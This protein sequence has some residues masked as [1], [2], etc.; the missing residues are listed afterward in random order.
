MRPVEL[1]PRRRRV[2]AAVGS[3]AAHTGLAVLLVMLRPPPTPPAA[4]ALIEIEVVPAPAVA[5]APAAPPPTSG[6]SAVPGRT[7]AAA[8]AGRRGRAVQVRPSEPADPLADLSIRYEAPPGA[9]TGARGGGPGAALY[10]NGTGNDLGGPFGAGGGGL[11]KAPPVPKRASLARP[12]RPR[13][14][15]AHWEYRWPTEY[16]DARVLVELDLDAGGGVTAVRV[17]RGFD[18]KLDQLATA[19]ARTFEFWPALDDDGVAIASLYR[20]EFVLDSAPI[21]FSKALGH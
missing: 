10:G 15:Y 8:T 16:G 6:G 17:V 21:D 13:H 4:P 3:F 9:G 2:R 1:S 18:R 12:P 20:W 19:R 11:L 5:P 7:A 14:D